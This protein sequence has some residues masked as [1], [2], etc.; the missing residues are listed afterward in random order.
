MLGC[1]MD[2]L[3][4]YLDFVD[5][6]DRVVELDRATLFHVGLLGSVSVHTSLRST[7]GWRMGI[8]G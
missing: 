6:A 1:P 5:I 3:E 2:G 7:G 8:T 4:T